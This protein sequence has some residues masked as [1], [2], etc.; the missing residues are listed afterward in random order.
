MR[1]VS[2]KTVLRRLS[3]RMLHAER[4]KNLAVIA[5][6]I[7]TSV[8]FTAFFSIAMS[9]IK[10]GERSTMRQVGGTAMAGLKYAQKED[11]EKLRSDPQVKDISYRII[12]GYL[13]E[14]RLKDMVV[15]V[16]YSTDA[17][18]KAC[19]SYP[20]TGRMPEHAGEIAVSDIALEKLGAQ[21]KL[22]ETL[23]LHIEVNKQIVEKTFTLVGFWAGDPV[24]MSQMAYIA[25]EDQEILAPQPKISY[26]DSDR[27]N[28]DGYWSIDFN[29]ASSFDISRQVE[30][31]AQR[32]GYDPSV[33]AFAV[34]WA[35]AAS[36]V[37]SNGLV[38]G[39]FIL[40]M[41]LLAGYLII[42]NIFYIRVT[43]D[44]RQY[45][46]LKTIGT[47][48][49]QLRFL[50]LRQALLLTAAGVPVGLLVGTGLSYLLFPL[51]MRNS[52][53]SSL[54]MVF[55]VHPMIYLL[56]IVFVLLT[57]LIGCR[58]PGR[59]AARVSPIEA[60]KYEE[61]VS[62]RRKRKKTKAVS[63][64]NLAA[65][66]LR[67]EKKKVFA[68]VSSLALSVLLVGIISSVVA[69]MSPDKYVSQSIIG[70]INVS[71]AAFGN[72]NLSVDAS[73]VVSGEDQAALSSLPGVTGISSVYCDTM[74]QA[75]LGKK[76]ILQIDALYQ[77]CQQ[78]S[79]TAQQYGEELNMY[80][81]QGALDVEFYG[82][83]PEILPYLTINKGTIDDKMWATGE[84]AVVYSYQM[85]DDADDH[86]IELYEI[87]EQIEV[88]TQDGQKRSYT[89]MAIADLPYALTTKSYW[90]LSGHVMVPSSAYLDAEKESSQGSMVSILNVDDPQSETVYR[91]VDNYVSQTD[92]LVMTSKKTYLDQFDT[93]IRSIELVGGAL[94]LILAVIGI[95]NFA[96]S[97]ITGIWRRARELAIMQAVGMTGSQMIRMLMLEGVMQG[98]LT[99]AVSVLLHSLLGEF[100]V[101]MI[102]EQVWF[103]DYRFTIVPILFCAPAILLIALLIP[104]LV[105]KRLQKESVIERMKRCTVC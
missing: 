36:S 22:G 87:G 69:C 54:D 24:A 62:I 79:K 7:L 26:Y 38:I 39:G 53:M 61:T 50:V 34:N 46:L 48:G 18:A 45:G 70:D 93:F 21:K 28:Y 5:A 52:T 66:N 6:I 68:V 91:A 89:V 96:N 59:I 10:S 19:F 40:A 2:N 29:F 3:R 83:D 20:K 13:Q 27:M 1:K 37:D 49:R 65:E 77:R 30:A 103:F 14:P 42:Y 76:Q 72:V 8:L 71:D 88:I 64:W 15:E 75:V 78:G 57:V 84:Y 23:T 12:S 32:L 97:T 31:L 47:T 100:V 11:Y 17:C 105:G 55:S 82:I 56:S 51:I 73:T 63:L 85:A 98:L 4:R 81:E 99:M 9:L 86:A 90:M 35:Y 80:K 102:A 95:M 25:Q 101:R 74:A 16:Y 33:Y 67:R 41:I 104:L 58:K 44:I 60:V 94:A 92:N 43:S